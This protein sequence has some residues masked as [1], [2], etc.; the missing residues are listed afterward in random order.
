[1][2]SEFFLNFVNFSKYHSANERL[3]VAASNKSQTGTMIVAD[4]LCVGDCHRW[5]RGCEQFIAL[6]RRVKVTPGLVT[7]Y[8]C[9]IET[10]IFSNKINNQANVV[11]PVS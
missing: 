9:I 1:M 4:L 10:M 11:L 2:S 8:V 3:L 7:T 5:L 6:V